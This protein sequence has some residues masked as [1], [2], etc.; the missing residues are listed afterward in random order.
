M[1]AIL[2]SSKSSSSLTFT[3]DTNIEDPIRQPKPPLLGFDES[4]SLGK[5]QEDG[6]PILGFQDHEKL[7]GIPNAAFPLII[8]STITNNYVQ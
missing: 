2:K 8:T 7:D 3:I 6:R 4:T 1:E 5:E